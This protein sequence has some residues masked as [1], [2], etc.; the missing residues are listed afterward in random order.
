MKKKNH[1]GRLEN[2]KPRPK[3]VNSE[4]S[5]FTKGFS[6]TMQRQNRRQLIFFAI[7]YFLCLC[8][9][10]CMCTDNHI[11]PLT[12]SIFIDLDHTPGLAVSVCWAC[13]GRCS[14]VPARSSSAPS[15]SAT[16]LADWLLR[17]SC[18]AYRHTF[19][20]RS[21]SGLQSDWLSA[22]GSL[23]K[24]SVENIMDEHIMTPRSLN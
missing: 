24:L 21:A 4:T 8:L 3:L 23:G 9:Y 11:V 7:S 17:R 2:F 16:G 20:V 19:P 18:P 14:E 13:W 5:G 12:R 15:P 1:I 6:Y 10:L 22:S